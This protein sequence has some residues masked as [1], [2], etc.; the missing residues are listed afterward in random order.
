MSTDLFTV[1]PDDL[2]DLAAS[3]MHWRHVRHVPVEDDEGRLVGLLSHRNLLRLVARRG[4][5]QLQ[6]AIAVRDIMKA[7][8]LTVSPQTPTLEAIDLMRQH[9]VG[10]L[11]VVEG[12]ALV[13]IVT[14]HD[15]LSA[16]ARLFEERLRA[17]AGGG[18]AG[19][20]V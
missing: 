15:F 7:D 20:R 4:T 1:R 6:E 11:P 5:G 9:G 10:C 14:A 2:V 16:S 17:D 13:G 18:A 8:P 12:G 19:G 3:V